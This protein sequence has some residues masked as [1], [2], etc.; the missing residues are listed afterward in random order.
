M[1]VEN[2]H[3]L[4]SNLTK[5][6]KQRT[7]K[8]FLG[9]NL[10]FY[11]RNCTMK[12]LLLGLIIAVTAAKG[13]S[14]TD[15]LNRPTEPIGGVAKPGLEY[16]K[17]K[18]TEEQRKLLKGKE[19]EFIFLVDTLGVAIL[20]HVNGNEDS[21]IIDSYFSSWKPFHEILFLHQELFFMYQEQPQKN[22]KESIS[23]KAIMIPE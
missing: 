13:I 17:I 15:T 3:Y 1:K 14:Q 8:G 4:S 23:A 22:Q 10:M 19:L 21:V 12:H 2:R 5:V 6:E 20:E 9:L 16:F 7:L 18:F 11:I